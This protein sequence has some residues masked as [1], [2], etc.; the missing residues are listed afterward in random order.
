MR[1]IELA[2]NRLIEEAEGNGNSKEWLDK[3]RGTITAELR[4]LRVEVNLL[5]TA[6]YSYAS[7]FDSKDEDGCPDVRSIH[8]NIRALKAENEALR[9]DAERYRFIRDE[10][11]SSDFS[12]TDYSHFVIYDAALDDAIDYEMEQAK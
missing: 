11:N 1:A 8:E 4:Q 7:L 2:L 9:K 6:R 10:S 5:R 3:M 12:V